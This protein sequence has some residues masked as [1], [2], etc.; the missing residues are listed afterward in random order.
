MISTGGFW[1]Q[2]AALLSM[3]RRL[4]TLGWINSFGN[5]RA[6]SWV[7]F[8]RTVAGHDEPRADCLQLLDGA[9]DNCLKDAAGEVQPAQQRVDPIDPA[10]LLSVSNRV[11]APAWPSR[12]A[13][14]GPCSARSQP[15]PGR[16][17][18]ADRI[19]MRR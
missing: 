15:A 10:E 6:N 8:S 1:A 16:R 12:S 5:S 2:F 11:D 4:P 18:S 14:R 17:G 3:T 7:A 13:P 19:A 9:G